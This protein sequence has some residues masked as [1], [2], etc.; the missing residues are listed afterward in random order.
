MS[1]DVVK[2][3]EDGFFYFV[4]RRDGMIKCSGFRVSPTEVEEVLMSSGLL[5]HAA[6]IGLPDA[7]VGERVHAVCIAAPDKEPDAEALRARCVEQLPLHMQPREFEFVA[8][9]PRSPNG[10]VDYRALRAERTGG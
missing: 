7:N 9:L 10:K 1:G 2:M 4:G 8:E 6:V 3:D 5:A